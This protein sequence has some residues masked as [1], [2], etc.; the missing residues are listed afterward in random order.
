MVAG[1]NSAPDSRTNA[2]TTSPGSCRMERAADEYENLLRCLRTCARPTIAAAKVLFFRAHLALR[3]L[4][5]QNCRG[6]VA[7]GSPAEKL[8][9]LESRPSSVPIC[10][11]R[12]PAHRHRRQKRQVVA[13]ELRFCNRAKRAL[14]AHADQFRPRDPSCSSCLAKPLTCLTKL[15][16]NRHIIFIAAAGWQIYAE[17]LR[18]L[19]C[20]NRCWSILSI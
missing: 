17:R 5:H 6:G 9:L 20:R 15:S 11:E 3:A 12:L 16:A 18:R 13:R 1:H 8:L 2:E 10:L 4:I 7:S 19:R 14:F